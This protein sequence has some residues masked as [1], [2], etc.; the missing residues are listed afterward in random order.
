MTRL[1]GLND[2]SVPNLFGSN[3]SYHF[4]IRSSISTKSHTFHWSLSPS[5]DRKSVVSYL[6]HKWLF[7]NLSKQER[8]LFYDIPESTTEDIIFAALKARALNYPMDSI[9]K[10]LKYS[11]F[12]I[13]GRKPPT[14][15]RW[16]GYRSYQLT[17]ELI[18]RHT[19]ARK[20]KRYTGWRRHQN[21][22]GSLAPPKEDPF[23]IVPLIENDNISTFLQI[24]KE[25]ADRK[26]VV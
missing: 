2:I 22:Q 23:D 7:G 11:S 10:S 19:N 15:E 16:L 9:R 5:G 4:E 21:D 18:I 8:L 3:D 17:F 13:F 12:L 6:F 14:I 20:V 1:V 26:S 24:V 25:V